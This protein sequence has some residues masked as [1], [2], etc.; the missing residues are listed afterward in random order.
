VSE[1]ALLKLKKTLVYTLVETEVL[2]MNVLQ[3]KMTNQFEPI[4]L[5]TRLSSD[6]CSGFLRVTGNSTTWNMA[7]G[8]GQL[9]YADCSAQSLKQ[10]E[11]HLQQLGCSAAVVA[12]KSLISEEIEAWQL[13][14]TPGSV[15]QTLTWQVINWLH[16]RRLLDASQV[17]LVAKRITEEA[18]ESLLWLTE[19]SHEWQESVFL[20]MKFEICPG[21]ALTDLTTNKL[22][23]HYLSRLKIWR[24]FSSVI[25]SPH[26]RPYLA[27]QQYTERSIPGGTLTPAVLSKIAQLMRG[28]SFRQLSHLLNQD[29]LKIIHLLI[30]YIQ[31]G[32][33]CLREPAAPFHTLPL[34]NQPLESTSESSSTQQQIRTYKIACID[35]SPTILDEIQRFLG[36]A[37]RYQVTRIDDPIKA[38]AVIFRLKPDLI[39][40]DITMPGINGYNLCTLFRNSTALKKT[41]IIMIT[42]NKG[43]I[44]KARAKMVGA[45]D[46]LTKPFDQT[47]LI[48]VIDKHLN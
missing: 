20:A 34:V 36:D 23:E 40:M 43:L 5:L 24:K 19:G 45:S 17:L 25:C 9:L 29:E 31:Q 6:R 28:V 42:G 16:K 18:F 11:Y 14:P 47:S 26:Q 48:T 35:D 39:L 32:V 3:T 44:D 46:Y 10:I 4:S 12:I 8:N 15:Q 41:P 27:N 38:S 13:S 7:L 2:S 37:E 22:L 30:P 21:L 1:F 33:I